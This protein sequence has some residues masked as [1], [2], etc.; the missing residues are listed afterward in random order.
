MLGTEAV[1][2]TGGLFM[3]PEMGGG[4]ADEPRITEQADSTA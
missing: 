1:E 2:D 4:V 3:A